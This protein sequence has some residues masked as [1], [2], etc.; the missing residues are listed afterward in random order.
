MIET[1]GDADV[2]GRGRT[3]IEPACIGVLERT[4][5]DRGARWSGL[6]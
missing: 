3:E 1:F 4:Q 2:F 5:A 6:Q